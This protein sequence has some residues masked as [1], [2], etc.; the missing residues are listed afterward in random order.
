MSGFYASNAYNGQRG[1]NQNAGAG[2]AIRIKQGNYWTVDRAGNAHSYSNWSAGRMAWKIPIGWCRLLS[3]LT[4][5]RSIDEPEYE[6]K[7]SVNARPLLF[8]GRND[9]Y[10]QEFSIDDN[11]TF[12]IRKFGHTL[13]RTQNCTIRLDE[14]IIQ[15]LHGP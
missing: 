4:D 5:F 11:G 8:G 13:E 9:L 7:D 14:R 2:N 10:L 1:H 12:F 6:I 15:L 3:D